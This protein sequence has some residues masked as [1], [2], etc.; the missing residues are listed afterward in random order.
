MIR[1]PSGVGV[2]N[3]ANEDPSGGS[4]HSPGGRPSFA[5]DSTGPP[6]APRTF[7]AKEAAL[8]AGT[9]YRRLRYWLSL[10]L[11]GPSLHGSDGWRLYSEADVDRLRELQALAGKGYR[12]IQDATPRPAV[13]PEALSE[14]ALRAIRARRARPRSL[15]PEP[16]GPDLSHIEQDPWRAA[17]EAAWARLGGGPMEEPEVPVREVPVREHWQERAACGGADVRIFYPSS[18]AHTGEAKRICEPCPVRAECLAFALE[19]DE[20]WGVWGGLDPDER[21]ALRTD[22]VV[23]S[24]A[25][26]VIIGADGDS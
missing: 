9:T 15:R 13:E 1:G 2:D 25:G 12:H 19:R 11:I 18:G 22:Y 8:A 4:P 5:G 10:G 17:E 26:P 14:E 23:G 16:P 6:G 24:P 20:E 3:A 7:T 21:R